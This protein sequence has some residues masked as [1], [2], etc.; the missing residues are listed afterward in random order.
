MSER[1]TVLVTGASG[2]LG[3]AVV[4][5]LA[6]RDMYDVVAVVSGR[7]QVAFPD[8]V[9]V[10]TADLVAPDACEKLLDRVNPQFLLHLAWDRSRADH[11]DAESNIR[12]LEVS[13]R[14]LRAF[15]ANKGECMLFAGTCLEYADVS[16]KAQES[17]QPRR[18][19]VYGECKRA[20][21]DIMKN[22]CGLMGV[23]AIDARYFTLYGE[24]DTHYYMAIPQAVL[25]LSQDKPV[26]CRAPNTIRDYI[27][28]E[29]A[30]RA[31]VM[32]LESGCSGT[33]NIG[34]GQ[35]R[36]MKDIFMSIARTLHKE[37]LLSFENTDR[38][39]LILVADTAKL[40][41]ATGFHPAYDFE[42]AMEEMIWH[43]KSQKLPMGGGK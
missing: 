30:A 38:C 27:H 9:R 29:D 14:L 16:G 37:Q 10:E 33:V 11:S 32:L 34:S 17:G 12:W 43:I 26:V 4:R 7:H 13:T 36:A 40:R 42:Q 35:P 1:K 31:T 24:N 19:N 2:F 21:S 41:E 3:Q 28:V 8:G 20:F 18:M 22:Y 25:A 39:D 6:E 15:A 5:Q 23:R